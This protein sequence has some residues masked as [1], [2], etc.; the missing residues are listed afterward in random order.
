MKRLCSS[1][2]DKTA[3]Q[4]LQ[5]LLSQEKIAVTTTDTVLGLIAPLTLSGFTALNEIKGRQDKP[6]LVLISDPS[7]LTHFVD[8]SSFSTQIACLVSK[9]WPGPL[10][11]IF[12]A[13]SGVPD[14]L[15]SK[16]GT[17]A[18]RVP[19]HEGLLSIL[20]A[21]PGLFSTSAN[22]A[23]KQV[24]EKIEDLDPAI[25]GAVSLCVDGG[26]SQGLPSTLIDCSGNEI[27]I[28]REGAYS[29]E[30]LAKLCEIP[31]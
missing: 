11:I 14:F 18:L 7:K 4:S 9:C 25:L 21:F 17:I 3:I 20:E 8:I 12:K 13:K 31:F 30:E 28:V 10:T 15:Q 6:Y 16:D 5:E 1:W 24:P 23:G 29:T 22:L 19:R 27:R 26:A 2:S